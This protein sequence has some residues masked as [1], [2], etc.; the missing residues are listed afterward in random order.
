MAVLGFD[1][2]G[3]GEALLLD[4]ILW[5]E[6]FHHSVSVALDVLSDDLRIDTTR[7]GLF[8]ISIGG[9]WALNAAAVDA[10][11][12]ALYDLGGPINTKSFARV[13]FVIKTRMCQVTGARDAQAIT[14]VLAKNSTENDAILSRVAC[15]VR[16]MHGGRDRVVAVADKEWLR[17]R[18]IRFGHAPHVSLEII[19][20][21]DHCCTGHAARIRDDL[22]AFFARHLIESGETAGIS[23]ETADTGDLTSGLCA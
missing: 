16:I 12:K 23:G 5:T 10:R 17:D 4:G 20:G 8:G 1:G 11:I 13:P 14:E 15:A 9:M 19:P 3:Q 2:P 18:L 21:G 22:S 7:V 6:D